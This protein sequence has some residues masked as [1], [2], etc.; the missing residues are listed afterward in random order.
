MRLRPSLRNHPAASASCA[1]LPGHLPT[2]IDAIRPSIDLAEKARAVDPLAEAI[3]QN[4]RH[5]VRRLEQA[6]PIIAE[7]VA[8]GQVKVLGASTTSLLARSRSSDRTA[9]LPMTVRPR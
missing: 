3:A 8:H 4:V 7:R 2:L 1:A 6:K 9:A 5:N